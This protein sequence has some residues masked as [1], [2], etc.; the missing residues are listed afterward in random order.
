MKEAQQKRLCFY[1]WS[2]PRRGSSPSIMYSEA[3]FS[4]ILSPYGWKRLSGI[5]GVIQRN[6][7]TT[8]HL[9]SRLYKDHSR[10][11]PLTLDKLFDTCWPWTQQPVTRAISLTHSERTSQGDP[12][13][14]VHEMCAGFD[15][16]QDVRIR[17][18]ISSQN[19]KLVSR[20][21]IAHMLR[22]A[23]AWTSGVKICWRHANIVHTPV[24]IPCTSA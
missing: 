2:Y 1:S 7:H 24:R 9:L 15:H 20:A 21:C 10:I 3:T 6:L 17:N 14:D 11:T 8:W 12:T 18:T 19:L 5:N 4:H 23:Y 13:A 16:L 22:L